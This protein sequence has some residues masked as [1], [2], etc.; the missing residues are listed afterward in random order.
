LEL[1][2]N[3]VLTLISLL[4]KSKFEGKRGKVAC[5]VALGMVLSCFAPFIAP[6][7]FYVGDKGMMILLYLL[8]AALRT[9]E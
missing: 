3:A 8:P 9:K 6:H 2:A 7:A 4:V 5:A 1:G